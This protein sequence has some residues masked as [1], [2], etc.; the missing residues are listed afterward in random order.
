MESAADDTQVYKP[1]SPRPAPEERRVVYSSEPH[2]TFQSYNEVGSYPTSSYR[3]AG[4]YYLGT[5]SGYPASA[6]AVYALPPTGVTKIGNASSV[7]PTSTLGTSGLQ[8][9]STYPTYGYASS[10]PYPGAGTT[11]PGNITYQQPTYTTSFESPS[12]YFPV[13]GSVGYPYPGGASAYPY[14][15]GQSTMSPYPAMQAYPYVDELGVQSYPLFNGKSSPFS[16]E[17]LASYYQS[18]LASNPA[19]ANQLNQIG[20]GGNPGQQQQFG[21]NPMQPFTTIPSSASNKGVKGLTPGT[22]PPQRKAK[23]CC[24]C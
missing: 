20:G 21:Q 23:G 13:S 6:T 17:E 4:D 15:V 22:K 8:G 19:L 12:S 14:N 10:T 3:P 18:Y 11:Y 16:Q 9:A 5:S 7:Y 24:G 2:V 1:A